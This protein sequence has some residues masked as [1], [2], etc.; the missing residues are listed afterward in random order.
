MPYWLTQQSCVVSVPFGDCG[1]RQ[2]SDNVNTTSQVPITV[3]GMLGL[4]LFNN[5]IEIGTF[6]LLAD[7]Q[8]LLLLIFGKAL[9]LKKNQIKKLFCRWQEV[10]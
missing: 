3:N 1:I 9:E 6:E 10:N 5:Y 7:Y 4:Q 8:V 2:E